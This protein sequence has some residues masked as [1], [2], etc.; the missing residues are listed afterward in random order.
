MVM[1]FVVL[2]LFVLQ[3]AIVIGQN[4]E[5]IT[6]SS[7]NDSVYFTMNGERSSIANTDM[8]A[9]Y[10]EDGLVAANAGDFISAENKF[11]VGLLYDP[12]N[13]QLWYNL[14]LAQYYQGAYEDAIYSFDAAVEV[15]PSNPENYNQRGLS[16]AMLGRYTDAETDF[17]IL[18]KYAPD[19]PMGNFNYGILKLQMGDQATACTYLHKADSLGYENAPTVISTYC[20]MEGE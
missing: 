2:T 3:T 1:R 5:P 10:L 13:E 14:G 12:E 9:F 16:K 8:A 15:D 7:D 20:A 17:L 4:T 11:R 18:F 6:V 19:H